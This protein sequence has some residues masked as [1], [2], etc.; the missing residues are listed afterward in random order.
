MIWSYLQE[1][2]GLAR[3]LDDPRRLGWVSAYMGG[4]HLHTGAHVTEVRTFAQRVEAIAERLGDVPL[5]IAAQY[6]LT[7]VPNLSG[8]Y[9]GQKVSAGN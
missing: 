3:T 1:A 8:D 7:A 5:R 9:C 6:Y 4:H 2:E